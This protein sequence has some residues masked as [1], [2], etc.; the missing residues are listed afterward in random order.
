[1]AQATGGKRLR[2]AG[3]KGPIPIPFGCALALSVSLPPFEISTSTDTLFWDGSIANASFPVTA[4]AHIEHGTYLGAARIA[5]EGVPVA[6]L[7]FE[8]AVGLEDSPARPI[9][10]SER[11]VRSIFASYASEDR[12]EVLQWARGAS[13]AGVDVFVDVIALREGEN[14]GLELFKQ[15]PSKDLFCLFW[16]RPA[17]QSIWVEKE[18]KCALVARGL[19]YIH[20]VP[21]V[22]PRLVPPPPELG[23]KHFYSLV[24]LLIEYERRARTPPTHEPM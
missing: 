6:V 12:V 9:E 14:W 18:W 23:S 15:V 20:P 22:D 5:C 7:N 16:S 17:S 3:A 21:L 2:P 11:R 1:V 13:V 19:D 4:P 10:T 8:I 24:N